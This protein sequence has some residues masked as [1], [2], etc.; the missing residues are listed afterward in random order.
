MD[1]NEALL[2]RLADLF[3][4]HPPQTEWRREAHGAI[5]DAAFGFAK[6]FAVLCP[7]LTEAELMQ[8]IT[9]IQQARMLAN[10]IITYKEVLPAN[11]ANPLD[12][13]VS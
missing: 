13:R 12:Q 4:Y 7:D 5:N 3:S 9:A 1:I 8:V 11:S 2:N 10:Q 6:A